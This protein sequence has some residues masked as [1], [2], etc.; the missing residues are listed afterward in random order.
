MVPNESDNH[1][2]FHCYVEDPLLNSIKLI[3]TNVDE[4]ENENETRTRADG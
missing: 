3:R 4:N 1:I 2:F